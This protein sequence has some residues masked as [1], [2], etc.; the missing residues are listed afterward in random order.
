MSIVVRPCHACYAC[1]ACYACH[2][3]AGLLYVCAI[4]SRPSLSCPFQLI[5]SF[6]CIAFFLIVLIVCFGFQLESGAA[7][8]H[9]EIN[10]VFLSR[11]APFS[12]SVVNTVVVLCDA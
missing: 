3:A 9:Q 7:F 11:L 5:V 2:A 12:L 8:E 1:Y 6:S 10:S 4:D